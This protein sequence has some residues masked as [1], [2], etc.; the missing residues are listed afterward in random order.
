MNHISMPNNINET[1]VQKKINIFDSI[2]EKDIFGI[3]A[4]VYAGGD[5]NVKNKLG[6][7]PMMYAIHEGWNSTEIKGLL[8]N[9]NNI[10]L[11]TEGPFT[12]GYDKPIDMAILK[13]NKEMTVHL[14]DYYGK[15]TLGK[16]IDSSKILSKCYGN[17]K[18]MDSFE[19]LVPY[20]DTKNI[21]KLECD[22]VF[23][24]NQRYYFYK[25]KAEYSDGLALIDMILSQPESI[26]DN[27]QDTLLSYRPDVTIEFYEHIIKFGYVDEAAICRAMCKLLIDNNDNGNKFYHFEYFSEQI[28]DKNPVI[29]Y[30]EDHEN[31]IVHCSKFAKIL[32]V[33][34]DE[35][36]TIY[37]NSV[38]SDTHIH[39]Y[40]HQN[41]EKVPNIN[42]FQEDMKNSIIDTKTSARDDSF[43][44][45]NDVLNDVLQ[46]DIYAVSNINSFQKV[47][48]LDTFESPYAL[49]NSDLDLPMNKEELIF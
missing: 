15:V 4:Y 3:M 5:I 35:P 18:L 20:L 2:K 27:Y 23:Y 26:P 48:M 30:L 29:K 6:A 46:P 44:F 25:P 33:E 43:I 17:L 16:E 34:Y 12:Y 7:T 21:T 49:L 47:N 45:I 24:L 8:S 31:Q 37:L 11:S 32:G 19:V 40:I 28:S 41:T 13:Y 42:I 9:I 14:L 22:F 36:G 39:K 1:T 38:I 10:D